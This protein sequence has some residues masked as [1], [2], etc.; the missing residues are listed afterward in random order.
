VAEV[1]ELGDKLAR[2]SGLRIVELGPAEST[3]FKQLYQPPPLT[4][5]DR[6]GTMLRRGLGVPRDPTMAAAYYTA[7][8]AGGERNAIYNVARQLLLGEGVRRDYRRGLALLSEAAAMGDPYAL[9]RLAGLH[10]RGMGFGIERD[11]EQ[12][13]QL[14]E[15]ACDAG[16]WHAGRD[17]ARLLADPA[18]ASTSSPIETA[19]AGAD[20]ARALLYMTF[21]GLADA[22]S[23]DELMSLRASLAKPDDDWPAGD[24]RC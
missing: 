24:S 1:A 21:A 11:P 3:L 19:A 8:A 10:L 15:A 2:R 7:A 6:M 18:L 20:P 16:L 17:A 9:E 22:A 12:A 5:L 23:L 13:R 4:G 14:F